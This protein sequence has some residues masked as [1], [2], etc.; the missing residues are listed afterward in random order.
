MDR[1]GRVRKYSDRI[2]KGFES[3]FKE[4]IL[5]G[6]TELLVDV[7]TRTYPY[8][9]LVKAYG[10]GVSAVIE[11]VEEEHKARGDD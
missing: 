11:I 9:D 4:E 1:N 7:S 2:K 5:K 3:F 8:T 10:A 6:R